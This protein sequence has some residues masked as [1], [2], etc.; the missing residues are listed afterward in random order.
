[1]AKLSDFKDRKEF[2]AYVRSM[3]N[4]NKSMSNMNDM[5]KNKKSGKGLVNDLFNEAKNY[6]V[7]KGEELLK[8]KGAE[9]LDKG[10]NMAVKKIKGGKMKGKGLLSDIGKTV[11][12]TG[13]NVIPM[14]EVVRDIGS[15][16][17]ELLI[18]KI[19]GGLN[20]TKKNL[21]VGKD[22]TIL[23]N[24][25]MAQKGGALKVMGLSKGGALKVM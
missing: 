18:D 5:K 3:K 24:K 9:L 15:N 23:I 25:N 21:L 12:K 17:G 2:M 11:F 14:P 4:K 10:I 16:V 8:Q 19:G 20:D 22:K 13:M 7:N 6:A 1:M